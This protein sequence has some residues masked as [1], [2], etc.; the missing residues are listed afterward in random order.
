MVEIS[1]SGVSGGDQVYG[2]RCELRHPRCFERRG[3]QLLL[4]PTAPR[5]FSTQGSAGWSR[6]RLVRGELLTKASV[7]ERECGLGHQ[8]APEKGREGRQQSTHGWLSTTGTKPSLSAELRIRAEH[9]PRPRVS[10]RT[11]TELWLASMRFALDKPENANGQAT[12]SS[13]GSNSDRRSTS[14]FRDYRS[15]GGSWRIVLHTATTRT[16]CATSCTS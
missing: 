3:Q 16:S 9:G 4:T 7:F 14:R 12:N 11:S 2:L 8:Q 5:W 6:G 13:S 10:T 15:G 1:L